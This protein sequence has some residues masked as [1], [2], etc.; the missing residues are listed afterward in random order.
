[1][2][3]FTRSREGRTPKGRDVTLET[4]AGAI[5]AYVAIH[6]GGSGPGVLILPDGNGLDDG[7]RALVNLFAEEGYVAL[8]PSLGAEAG[9]DDVAA[10]TA[11][12]RAMAEHDGGVAALGHGAGGVLACRAAAASDFNAIVAFDAAGLADELD[13]LGAVQCPV[14]LQFGTRDAASA[15]A[16]AD[17]LASEKTRRDGSGVYIYPDAAP[18]FAIPGRDGFDK[19]VDGL[20]HSRTLELIRRAMGPYYDFIA[21]FDEHVR[22]E[23]ETRDVDATM[24]T[25]VDEP[26]VNHAPTLAGGVGHDHLKR[27]YKYHF[28]DQN[29]RERESLPIAYTLGPDRVVI[30]SIARFRHDQV[31]DRYFPNIPPTDKMVEISITLCVRF[32]GDRVC[33]EHIYWD[34]GS[35][36]AQIGLI[37]ATNLPIAGPEAA[38]KLL[39]ETR[40]SN[41]FMRESWATSEGK[42][43]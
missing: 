15:Q 5:D 20:A 3:Q 23:F 31:L 40:P 12:L 37:D 10:A 30:E 22:H 16:A 17:R 27:F 24:E 18:G 38:A 8:A 11:A 6:H 9:P 25:M 33:H 28:V 41:V 4:W 21:L 29:S 19:R 14:A 36:L 1:M 42:P 2:S 34:Q 32:R 39:D 35:A 43:I 26:Y 7:A 13:M